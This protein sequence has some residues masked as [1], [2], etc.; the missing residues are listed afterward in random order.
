MALSKSSGYNKPSS[1]QN[2]S[3]NSIHV[4][5]STPLLFDH[6]DRGTLNRK[7]FENGGDNKITVYYR[8]LTFRFNM[9]VLGKL[10]MSP[11]VCKHYLLDI[12]REILQM[13]HK[14]GHVVIK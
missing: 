10:Y 4:P 11:I 1:T 14:T 6:V 2:K 7:K 12:A 8:Y 5:N 13:G 3:L 9:Q